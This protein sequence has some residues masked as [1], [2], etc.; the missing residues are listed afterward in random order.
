MVTLSTLQ[1]FLLCFGM[2]SLGFAIGWTLM[3]IRKGKEMKE[4]YR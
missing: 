3:G 1:V 2:L 4:K